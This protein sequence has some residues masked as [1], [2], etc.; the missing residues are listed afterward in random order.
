MTVTASPADVPAGTLVGHPQ[1]GLGK[2]GTLLAAI[3]ATAAL[4]FGNQAIAASLATQLA[5]LQIE[6]VR[7]FMNSYWVSADQ[8]IANTT[9]AAA[10]TLWSP[11]D[12]RLADLLAR[13]A[14]RQ[15]VVNTLVAAG[16]PSTVGTGMQPSQYSV[17]Y[18]PSNSAYPLTSPDVKLYSLQVELVNYLMQKAYVTAATLLAT[19]TGAQTYPWNGYASGYTWFSDDYA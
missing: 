1:P 5:E 7:Y 4:S 13:I 16:T 6:A 15:A 17:A 11:R 19:M 3:A 8:I 10:I 9:V 14:T 18:P 12:K 2:G